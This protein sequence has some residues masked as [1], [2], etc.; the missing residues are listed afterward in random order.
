MNK[1]TIKRSRRHSKLIL[2]R[3]VIRRLANPELAGVRAGCGDMDDFAAEI[4]I[5]CGH[6]IYSA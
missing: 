5:G 1:R 3:D 4:E 6:P 2:Q